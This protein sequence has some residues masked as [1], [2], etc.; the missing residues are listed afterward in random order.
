M[1]NAENELFNARSNLVIGTY[2]DIV[3]TYFVDASVGSLASRF[4][5]AGAP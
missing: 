4:G 2:D 5:G 1:L 3:N